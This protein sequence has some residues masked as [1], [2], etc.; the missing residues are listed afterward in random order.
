MFPTQHL[1]LAEVR[2]LGRISAAVT[3]TMFA[4]LAMSTVE[5]LVVARLGIHELAGVTLAL[6]VHLLVGDPEHKRVMEAVSQADLDW[7]IARLL[8]KAGVWTEAMEAALPD[9]PSHR[10]LVALVDAL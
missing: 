1:W 10:D 7:L 4:Q 8:R 2:A 9:M 6:S 3:V 5:T